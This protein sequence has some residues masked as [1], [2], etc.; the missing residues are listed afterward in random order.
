MASHTKQPEVLREL[1]EALGNDPF[2]IAECLARP[3]LT[4]RLM[5]RFVGPKTE[6]GRFES[7]Q[8]RRAPHRCRL[9]AMLRAGM[10]TQ[11]PVIA[12]RR[13]APPPPP[14]MV[15]WWPGDGTAADIAGPNDGALHE[16]A[17]YG[18]GM[19]GQA[20]HF[21]GVN[22]YMQ[23]PVT[24]FPV[25]SHDRTLEMWVNIEAFVVAESFFA[26][27]GFPVPNSF[28]GVGTHG[29]RR[30]TASSSPRGDRRC[31]GPALATGRWYHVAA[32][33]IGTYGRLYLD[34]ELVAEGDLSINTIVA[35][36]YT[37][38]FMGTVP[39]EIGDTRKLQGSVDEVTV[40]DR[41]LS[42][43][44][45][46]L[47]LTTQ[48]AQVSAK[49]LLLRPPRQHLLRPQPRQLRRRPR[50]ANSDSDGNPNS[51]IDGNCNATPTVSPTPTASSTPTPGP[52]R[53]RDLARRPHRVRDLACN[54]LPLGTF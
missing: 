22:D 50:D 42:D 35:E 9:H 4:E 41:A 46:S 8:N 5:R 43:S 10:P 47:D 21:D 48:A 17:G 25:G 7:L 27:Y 26:G 49:E 6:T 12:G 51:D 44:E 16:G 18:S 30:V 13:L 33:N 31:S 54:P 39:T 2:V 52:R 3:V 1:F 24:G 15:S 32:T 37:W 36:P 11:L 53:Q 23:A 28:Y 38:I 19:V 34:G 29:Y 14:N 45:I 20:F 40:Y